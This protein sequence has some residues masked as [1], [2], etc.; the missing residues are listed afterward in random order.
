MP[1]SSGNLQTFDYSLAVSTS[2]AN[3]ASTSTPHLR[4][5]L[6][7][8]GADGKVRDEVVEMNRAELERL[9]AEMDKVEKRTLEL[10]EGA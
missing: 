6:S 4:L 7:I 5:K 8:A 10:S 9:L 3:T 1:V 2:S